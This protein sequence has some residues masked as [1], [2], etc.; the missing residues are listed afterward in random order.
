IGCLAIAGIPF[1]SGFFSK[2]EILMNVFTSTFNGRLFWGLGM[3]AAMMTAYYMFRLLFVTFWGEYR[4]SEESKKHLH[5]SPSLMTIP[6]MVLAFLSLAGGVIGVPEALGGHHV[7]NNFLRP[8]LLKTTGSIAAIHELSH[9]NEWMLM[10][11]A[12]L[13]AI[14]GIIMA[15]VYYKKYDAAKQANGIFKFFE[16]KWYVDEIY[17][18]A[19]SKP[20]IGGSNLLEKFMEKSGIDGLVNGIGK[21]IQFGS[22]KFRLLQSGLVGFYLFMMVIG[23]ILL[24]VLQWWYLKF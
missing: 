5:E 19:V 22:T 10:G 7:L 4:G 8:V 21:L 1:F 15:Y 18:G 9:E 16:N 3:L 12:V 6:L 23:M 20:L 14:T 2:D 24:F 11:V 13:I 17:D